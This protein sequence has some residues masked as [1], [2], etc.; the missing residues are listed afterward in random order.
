MG[1][2]IVAGSMNVDLVAEVQAHPQVGETVL[3]SALRRT[4]GG[5]GLNQAIAAARMGAPTRFLGACGPD[6]DDLVDFMRS[7]G[8]SV[9]VER[10]S[11]PTG[12][13]MIVLADG[14]NSIVVAPGANSSLEPRHV[15]GPWSAEDVLLTQLEIGLETVEAFM[16]AGRAAGAR[17]I[18][19]AAPA[20]DLAQAVLSLADVLIVNEVEC[21]TLSGARDP[22]DGARAL[23]APGQTV[24]VTLGAQGA[25]LVRDEVVGIPARPTHAID[26]VGAGDCFAGALAARVLLG[27][28]LDEAVR[29]ACVAASLCVERSGAAVAMPYAHDVVTAGP[30][31]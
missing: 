3:A 28:D 1:S 21:R 17:T 27:D 22:A 23:R 15:A 25:L 18:L 2:V 9:T 10:V 12:T 29:R 7:E 13:A 16:R 24:V 4:P 26:T 5:K 30:H 31:A 11:V 8:L 6:G 14:Q 20:R 19:N